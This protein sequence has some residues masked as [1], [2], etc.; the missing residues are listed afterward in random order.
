MGLQVFDTKDKLLET[1]QFARLEEWPVALLGLQQAEK[2][3]LCVA[4]TPHLGQF[5]RSIC[6][7][8]FRERLGAAWIVLAG[9]QDHIR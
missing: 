7:P 6:P 2:F 8:I 4:T 3:T 5:P 9:S 1:Y